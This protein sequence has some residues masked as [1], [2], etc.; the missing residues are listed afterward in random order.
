MNRSTLIRYFG[1]RHRA[2]ERLTQRSF[3]VNGNT[4]AAKPYGNFEFTLWR[5]ATDVARALYT[6]KGA[7]YCYASRRDVLMVW[8]MG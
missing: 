6:G 3:R 7:A 8:S 1:W 2:G 4:T 5:E